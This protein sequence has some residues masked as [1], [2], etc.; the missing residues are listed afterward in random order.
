VCIV[1]GDVNVKQSKRASLI[2]RYDKSVYDR[3]HSEASKLSRRKAA[4]IEE[5][6]KAIYDECTFQ[7][8]LLTASHHSPRSTSPDNGVT[9]F[10]ST[11]DSR[12]ELLYQEGV[13]HREKMKELVL[14]DI[15]NFSFKPKLVAP[16]RD[17]TDIKSQG[18]KSLYLHGKARIEKKRMAQ[19]RSFS[20][21]CSSIYILR[22]SCVFSCRRNPTQ[23]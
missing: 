8:T 19:V 13:K 17:L 12:C 11:T 5:G 23:I 3:L 1:A 21:C 2:S 16:P 4:L 18:V 15:K 20:Q 9:T 10:G 6:V 14:N 7:P 22:L